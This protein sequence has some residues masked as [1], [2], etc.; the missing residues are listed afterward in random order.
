MTTGVAVTA[1][2]PG[3]GGVGHAPGWKH[4]VPAMVTVDEAVRPVAPSS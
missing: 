4:P 2:A 3:A 1:A